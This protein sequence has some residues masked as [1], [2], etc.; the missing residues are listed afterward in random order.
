M[1]LTAPGVRE[2]RCYRFVAPNTADAS[3]LCRDHVA[4]LLRHLR[5]PVSVDVAKLLV[6]E[7][8]SNAYRHTASAS[9]SLTTT[10][11]P[12]RV[13]VEVYDGDPTP[14]PPTP[15]DPALALCADHGRGLLMLGMLASRWDWHLC[16]GD[17]PF[18]KSVWFELRRQA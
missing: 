6:S 1:S 7:L 2:V 3:K 16:G 10:V 18:G 8:V 11:E 14:L 4:A 13:H 5:T 15:V 9:V 12:V 17:A